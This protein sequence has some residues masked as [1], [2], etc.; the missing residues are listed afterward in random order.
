MAGEVKD[1]K[2]KEAIANF[3]QDSSIKSQDTILF[4]FAGHSVPDNSGEV[5]MASSETNS[6]NPFI[7]GLPFQQL[8]KL[9]N[10][11][12]STRIITVLDCCHSGA[13][14]LNTGFRG[15]S[16]E[17]AKKAHNDMENKSNL[18]KQGSGKCLLAASES[19]QRAYEIKEE[20]HGVFTYYLLEGLKG[21]PQSVD[22]YGNVTV[23]RLA[24]YVYDTI[25]GLPPEKRPNQMPIKKVEGGGK[26]FL[27]YHPDLAKTQ[28]EM[29]KQQQ[30][31]QP[32]EGQT[33]QKD[34]SILEFIDKAR[35]LLEEEQYVNATKI[36]DT[37]L[38]LRPEHIEALNGK[39]MAL[40]K[41]KKYN[42]ALECFN[43]TLRIKPR[44]V[45][46]S[47]Y[48]EMI[49][50]RI[51]KEHSK[52]AKA[53]SKDI[54][55]DEAVLEKSSEREVIKALNESKQSPSYDTI[56]VPGAD[57]RNPY[58][59]PTR[60]FYNP[61]LDNKY[62]DSGQYVGKPAEDYRRAMEAAKLEEE[63]ILTAKQLPSTEQL[64][65]LLK[66]GKVQELNEM[67]RRHPVLPNLSHANLFR[68]KL[69]F[70]D[71]SR[72]DLSD[73]DLSFADLSRADLS[74]A[75]LSHANLNFSLIIGVKGYGSRPKCKGADFSNAIIDEE[76]LS[77]QLRKRGA[78]NV[79]SAARN[80]KELREKLE[81]RGLPSS[82]VKHALTLSRLQE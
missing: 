13:L 7:G 57:P 36:F 16:S 72:A 77:I 33:S 82:F 48:L 40:Y 73:A 28:P 59:D 27:A 37:I 66:R 68:A 58:N 54:S 69:T 38:I 56:V 64:I 55:Q 20:N 75:N 23:D 4:Y 49:T 43:E 18:L 61:R 17:A 45:V 24:D 47:D 76:R 79:P 53:S 29:L 14:E 1:R 6:K 9:M 71:L 63:K 30:Q 78:K 81:I 67:R 52:E 8:T 65:A 10:E 50:E 60:P 34:Y 21:K 62:N 11:S 46:A 3:F 42:E 2:M 35:M 74:D 26:I 19:T 5:F 39:G 80:K 70:A 22:D 12:Y 25:S 41:Q 32:Q 44:N 51:S 31:Q 15:D